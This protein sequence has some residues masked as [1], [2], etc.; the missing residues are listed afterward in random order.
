[1]KIYGAE[2]EGI[3]SGSFIGTSS[4]ANNA[5]T[6]SYLLGS[7]SSASYARNAETAS[8]FVGSIESASYSA[9]AISSSYAQTSSYFIGSVTS[10]SYAASASYF[11][12][13]VV[14]SSYST[15]SSYSLH[16]HEASSMTTLAYNGSGITITKG[17]VVRINGFSVYVGGNRIPSI[18]VAD[19]ST[20]AD[21]DSPIGIAHDDMP[22]FSAGKV[23]IKGY[24]VGL[25]TTGSNAGDILYLGAN[26]DWTNVEPVAPYHLVKIGQ[27][28]ESAEPSGSIFIDINA[29]F[30]LDE[31]HNV[32]ITAAEH[33]DLLVRSGSLFINSK[34]LSGSYFLSGSITGTASY[35]NWAESASYSYSSSH[36]NYSSTSTSSSYSISSS[37]AE[38]VPVQASASYSISSSFSNRSSIADLSTTSTSASYSVSSSY[39]DK[40][41]LADLSTT[42][43]HSDQSTSASYYGGSV[44]SASYSNNST[45]ADSSIS[46][47]YALSASW[48]PAGS[49]ISSSYSVSSSYSDFAKS[50]SH[51]ETASTASYLLGSVE[52]SSYSATAVSSSYAISASW[53]PPSNIG[54]ITPSVIDTSLITSDQDNYNP[55]GFSTATIVKLAG[56]NGINAITSFA[57][58]SNGTIIKLINTGSQPLY[59]PGDHPDGTAGNKIHVNGDYIFYPDTAVEIIYDTGSAVWYLHA[60][61]QDQIKHTIGTLQYNMSVG[62]ATA[63]DW[64]YF[65]I[66]ST[67][68]GGVGNYSG[69]SDVPPGNSFST[70]TSPSGAAAGI[71]SKGSGPFGETNRAHISA[72]F[73]ASISALSDVTNN[74]EIQF[75]LSSTVTSATKNNYSSVGVRYN[76]I[77]GSGNFQGFSRSSGNVESTVDLGIKVAAAVPYSIGI[78]LNAANSEVRFYI[79]GVYRG[80]VTSNLPGDSTMLGAKAVI[81]KSAGG[82]SRALYLHSMYARAVY[83]KLS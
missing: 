10:A 59:F 80:R 49:S 29:G 57:S 42:S 15:T 16:A 20:E 27:T 17:K 77:T 34:Q 2:I 4:Y 33:G 47:S 25:N 8:Y 28:L 36:S 31:L 43:S 24:H 52:S 81:V 38:A 22:N 56:N 12:G 67:N 66:L 46:A 75:S 37:Y 23:L 62:S 73:Y 6:A 83:P 26:G 82:T 18:V 63:G 68:G 11:S 70:G 40:S 30:E 78:E 19:Y 76:D 64:G 53:A 3:G 72:V 54:G 21:S 61:Y 14:T 60:G 74:F 48:S 7:I 69:T 9:W 39:S 44:V 32:K 65:N 1:M 58:Q 55:T 41:A 79:D 45:T 5:S 51:S 71:F 50:G 13:V 35:S